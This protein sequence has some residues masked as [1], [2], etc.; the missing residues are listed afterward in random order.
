VFLNRY[1]Y[2]IKKLVGTALKITKPYPYS[3]GSQPFSSHGP[4]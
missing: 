4:L 3:S 2:N 1:K